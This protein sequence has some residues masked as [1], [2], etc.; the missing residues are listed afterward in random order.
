MSRVVAIELSTF[1][2]QL[3]TVLSVVWRFGVRR[4]EI[5]QLVALTLLFSFVGMD[6]RAVGREPAALIDAFLIDYQEAFS[7]GNPFRLQS[8]DPGLRVFQPLLHCSWFDHV[9]AST[10]ALTDRHVTTLAAIEGKYEISFVKSQEDIQN[11]GSFTRGIAGVKVKVLIEGDS[12]TVLSHRVFPPGVAVH[13]YLSNDPRSWGEEHGLVERCLYRGLEYLREGDVKNAEEQIGRALQ[14]VQEGNVP[15]FL[16]GPAYFMAMCYYYSA[17]LKMKRGD[18]TEAAQEL[19]EALTLHPE[20]PA[21]LNLRAEIHFSD[22]EYDAALAS[23]RKSLTIHP[24]QPMVQEVALLLTNAAST[25][26]KRKRS[27]LLSLVNLPPFQ[28]V[29][30]LAPA[31]RRRPT[32]RVLVPLLAKAYLKVRDPE[33]ALEVLDTSRLVGKNVEVTYLAAR[34]HLKLQREKKALDLFEKLRESE[35]NYRDTL[36]FTV[37]LHAAMGH[38]QEAMAHIDVAI[39]YAGE[40]GEYHALKG[41]YSLMAGRFLDAV[42]ELEQATQSRLPAKLRAEVAY[43]F[44]RM[45]RQRR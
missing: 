27:L 8:Y 9:A 21:A 30:M 29:Q 1:N 41:R 13:G 39:E 16:M 23:W 24:D 20:Y 45:S 19:A 34:I 28:A 43:M 22:A 10:V 40:S 38:F 26:K 5:V 6:A 11:D 25:K 42:S 4:L 12:L 32:D 14:M 7:S 33:K 2:F 15:K 18:F 37:C 44:Q 31:V 17:M 35:P 36:V 3:S